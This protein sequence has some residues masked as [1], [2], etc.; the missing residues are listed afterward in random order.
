M[1]QDNNLHI[2]YT[3]IVIFF[4]SACNLSRDESV[5]H[6]S[7]GK[8]LYCEKELKTFS[9]SYKDQNLLLVSLDTLKHL[10]QLSNYLQLHYEIN[11]ETDTRRYKVGFPYSISNDS[12]TFKGGGQYVFICEFYN[13]CRVNNLRINPSPLRSVIYETI[14][15][16]RLGTFIDINFK[17]RKDDNEYLRIKFYENASIQMNKIYQLSMKDELT[18]IVFQLVLKRIMHNYIS[19][20]DEYSRVNYLNDVC[21]L[22]DTVYTNLIHFNK[23]NIE[24]NL[25]PVSESSIIHVNTPDD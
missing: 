10:A 20:I 6:G 3:V 16:D 18:P 5:F 13:I 24:I 19:A 9:A 17:G 11:C 7:N 12:I 21:N 22:E 2:L 1:E 4:I 14:H 25:L 8:Q 23:L 15:V